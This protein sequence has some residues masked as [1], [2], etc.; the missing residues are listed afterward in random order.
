MGGGEKIK[1]GEEMYKR[2][3]KINFSVKSKMQTRLLVKVL[4]IA[5]VALGLVLFIFYYYSN[6]EI[7]QSYRQFHVNAQNF[8]DLLMPVII[9]AAVT[10]VVAALALAI[11]FPLK[12]VGPLHRIEKALK[13]EV[14]RGNLSHEFAVRKHD[15]MGDLAKTLNETFEVLGGVVQK[16]RSASD[17]LTKLCE[18][19]EPSNERVREAARKIEEAL[20]FF[21]V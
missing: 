17:E 19:G 20:K 21:K 3:K 15:E 8:L 6:Q 2:R 4:T 10:G 18:E 7:G 16:A 11:F 12:I 14:V 5:L 1:I 13:E 9:I